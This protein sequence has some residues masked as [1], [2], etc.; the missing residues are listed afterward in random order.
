LK[1]KLVNGCAFASLMT[2]NH[3]SKQKGVGAFKGGRN[4]NHDD[5]NLTSSHNRINGGTTQLPPWTPLIQRN[6]VEQQHLKQQQK[7]MKAQNASPLS[8]TWQEPAETKENNA[9]DKFSP[10]EERKEPVTKSF[11]NTTRLLSEQGQEQY[12]FCLYQDDP[13]DLTDLYLCM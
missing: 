9:A 8:P 7:E 3:K 6:S 13:M 5:R 12:D 4:E 1:K 10:S 2:D 11:V